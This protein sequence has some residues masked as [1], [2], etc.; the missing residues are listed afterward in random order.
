VQEERNDQMM[1]HLL[2]I[3]IGVMIGFFSGLF[4]VG[5]S[6]IATPL[7]RLIG[8]SRMVAL[9]SPLPVTLPTAVIGG[10]IYWRRGMV[11]TKAVLWTAVGGVP[12]VA[13]GAFLTIEVPGRMLMALTGLFVVAVGVRLLFT[14]ADT[15]TSPPQ[16][17]ETRGLFIIVGIVT[18]ILSGLLANGGGFL[19]LPAY[20]LL[21]RFS[22]QEAAATSLVVVSLLAVPGTLFHYALGHIDFKIAALMAAGVI[23]ATYVGAH[24]GLSLSKEKARWFF[25][26]F[27]LLFGLFFLLRTLY[28]AEVYGWFS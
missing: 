9:G 7:L 8:I 25:G 15:K 19:L 5:G 13:V 21:F 4:G 14:P 1:H 18:G 12:T 16:K 24:V 17:R 11:H 20:L 26:L 3:G 2:L 22:P 27:L 10:I 6:S 23:P 28:R